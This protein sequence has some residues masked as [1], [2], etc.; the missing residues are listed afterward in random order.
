M[1]RAASLILLGYAYA[2]AA[3]AGPVEAWLWMAIILGILSGWLT[4]LSRAIET[5]PYARAREGREL[6]NPNRGAPMAHYRNRKEALADSWQRAINPPS[7]I[8]E[9]ERRNRAMKIQFER[10]RKMAEMDSYRMGL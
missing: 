9:L 4:I 10:A 5:A 6:L 2:Q 8:E 7:T 3:H 1:T